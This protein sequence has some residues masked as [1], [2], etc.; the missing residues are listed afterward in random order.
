MLEIVHSAPFTFYGEV[1]KAHLASNRQWYIPVN[2]VCQALGIDARSQRKRIQRDE[3]ISDRLVNIPM[4]TPYQDA[5]RIQEVACL[6]LRALPYWLGTID[7]SRVKDE[8]RKRVILFKREFAEAAWFVFRSDMIP[9]DILAEMDSYATPQEQEYAAIMDEARQLRKKLDL[10]SGK[11]E[12]ELERVEAD[13]QDLDGRLGSLETKLVGR[14]IINSAQA[15][16][17]NDMIGMVALSMHE[18]TPKKPK[19][20][21]FAEAHNDFKATFDVHIYSV[22]PEDRI[23]E[24]IN[25]LAGRW[26]RLN[27]GEPVPEIFRGGHQPSLF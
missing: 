22:L 11:V 10:L 13:I 2:E 15:K 20:L 3:A 6:N 27:P 23:E 4:E 9:Q 19:S 12:A 8:H 7:A 14:T 26:A 25:Y 24:A 5:T 21:C 17:L 18:K 16:S 1:F